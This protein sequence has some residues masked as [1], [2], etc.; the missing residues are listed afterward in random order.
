MN[1]NPYIGRWI[2]E[3]LKAN[4]PLMALVTGGVHPNKA[5]QSARHPFIIYDVPLGRD[6]LGVGQAR[7]LTRALC[8]VKVVGKAVDDQPPYAVM[9][10]AADMID[11]LLHGGSGTVA[12]L[13][14]IGESTRKQTIEYEDD[15]QFQHLGG[16]YEIQAYTL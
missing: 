4:G 5:P 13:I 15:H 9:V 12:G 14:H 3:T 2:A 8:T 1:E 11:S 7:V 10:Q 6:V 16:I